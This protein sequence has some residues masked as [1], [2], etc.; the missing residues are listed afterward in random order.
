[1]ASSFLAFFMKAEVDDMKN[2]SYGVP[3]SV[4]TI[5]T[6]ASI[7]LKNKSL[8]VIAGGFL[9]GVSALHGWQYRQ[10]IRQDIKKGENT[11]SLIDKVS[12][13][14]TKLEMFMR[15]VEVAAYLPGRIRLR[16]KSLVGNAALGRQ[17][18]ETLNNFTEIEN[19][20]VNLV[21][22]S[23]LIQYIPEILRQN[24]ELFRVERY[25]IS[26]VKGRK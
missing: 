8:H 23:I 21:T 16:S 9:L 1:M 4:L 7:L 25:I 12:L 24:E 19:V 20:D 5:S 6:A 10:K 13:P 17:V 11:L 18:Y 2:I 26:N 15:T 22:G 3:L 14:K